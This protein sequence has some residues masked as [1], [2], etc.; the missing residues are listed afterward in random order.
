MKRTCFRPVMTAIA[1][2]CLLP[3]ALHAQTTLQS[4]PGGQLGESASQ[5]AGQSAATP[6]TVD[7]TTNMA[8]SVSPAAS[9]SQPFPQTFPGLL[10][11][12]REGLR[13]RAMAGVERD[14]NVL[15]T[16]AGQISD[17]ITGLG[18]G[19]RY[20][21]RI[22]Q[23][24]VVLD[25]EANQYNYD[26]LGTDY[27]TLNYAAAWNFRFGQVDGVAS[28][29]RRQF[30][31]VTANGAVGI[32][33]RRTER[34]E[35]LEGRYRLGAAWR[36]L[37]G[38]QNNTTRSNDPTAWDGN[39]EVRSVRFGGAYEFASGSSITARWRVGD[40]EFQNAPAGAGAGFDDNEVDVSLRWLFSPRT[41]IN[42]R[43][44]HLDRDHDGAP[45]RNFSGVV[46]GADVSYMIT[47][48]TSVVAGYARDLGSYLGGTAGHLSSDRW[49]V[50]PTWRATE[51]ITVTGRY[52]HET[53]RFED[54]AGSP[55]V[56]RRDRFN[57]LSAG[58]DWSIRRSITLSA[59]LRNERRSSSLPAFNYRANVIGLS[60]RL[61]I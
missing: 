46:G 15:R 61:T 11:G 55:D 44:G 3:A 16:S 33:N 19:L 58:V 14:D 50:G 10:P 12:D 24:V 4:P 31:D 57:V 13:F 43:L 26:R 48:K 18:L 9:I 59:Q 52:E 56:G 41:T 8:T 20:T 30:R 37:A 36:I 25:V 49:F 22:S 39:Q 29:E 23:Q 32:V 38:L 54:A 28:A 6:M 2:A 35:L 5:P 40:G 42:A 47:A 21:K 1:A 7:A 60:A 27:N 51:L 53:R 17:T 34:Q 45:G